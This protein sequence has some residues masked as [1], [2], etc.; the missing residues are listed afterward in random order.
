[1]ARLAITLGLA[2]RGIG[3]PVSQINGHPFDLGRTTE[4]GLQARLKKRRTLQRVRRFAQ[5]IALPLSSSR[6]CVFAFSLSKRRTAFT[7]EFP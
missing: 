1:M 5:N 4:L 6:L 3:Q 7:G 2:A